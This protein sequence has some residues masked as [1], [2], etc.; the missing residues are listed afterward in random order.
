MHKACKLQ[1]HIKLK[2]KFRDTSLIE[3][4]HNP[5]TGYW[6]ALRPFKN[7]QTNHFIQ[8]HFTSPIL[9]KTLKKP[10]LHILQKTFNTSL[11]NTV[12]RNNST[13]TAL[14]NINNTIATSSIQCLPFPIEVLVIY[15]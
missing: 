2:M 8:T 12:I 7:Q 14:H 13:D 3:N 9:A 1:E 6:L 15:K 11:H 4:K 5:K 10:Y